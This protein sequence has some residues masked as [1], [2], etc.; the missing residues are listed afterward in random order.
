MKKEKFYNFKRSENNEWLII[1]VSY[2]HRLQ[3][4]KEKILP[5]ALVI[6]LLSYEG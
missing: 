5:L 2:L 3:T 1:K 4:T 6:T